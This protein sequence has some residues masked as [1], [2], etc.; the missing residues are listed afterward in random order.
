[1]KHKLFSVFLMI[2]ITSAALIAQA[3][4]KTP[5]LASPG[6]AQNAGP[7]TD[8]QQLASQ[9]SDYATTQCGEK[10]ADIALDCRVKALWA[11]TQCPDKMTASA[12]D[13]MKTES[14]RCFVSEPGFEYAISSIKPRK[15]EGDS[16]MTL[17]STSDGYRA[18]NVEMISL[19]SV[20]F[21][22]GPHV[23]YTGEPAWA[24]E[25]HFDVEAKFEPE[26][27]EALMKLS[28]DDRALVQSYML[29]KLL[30]ERMNLAVHVET[31]EVPTYDLVVGKN[32]PKMKL[33]EPSTDG[34]GSRMMP[35]INQ[36]RIVFDITHTP[37]WVFAGNLSAQAGRP[38]FDKTGLTGIYDFTLE[39]VRDQNL[40]VT[41]PADGAPGSPV[42]IPTDPVGPSL[43][44]AL[45][46]QLGLKLVPSR[47]PL[48]VVVIDHI[49]KPGAN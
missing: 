39:Y 25:L 19:V 23:Q 47:G 35:R 11:A 1:M 43:Q 14:G 33:A 17:G 48:K 45:E 15:N 9:I 27:G 40:S 16:R 2:A 42:V 29:Q 21:P 32:G 46:D 8:V 26:V 3:P 34:T 28:R 30:K 38:V 24:D 49:D 41:V 6:L 36:G 7:S 4:P 12:A 31:K 18:T 44:S 20:A 10:N 22:F 5:P 13:Q 37:M